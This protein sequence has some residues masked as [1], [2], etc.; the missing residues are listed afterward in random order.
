M[1]K[2]YWYIAGVVLLITGMIFFYINF[3]DAAI[4]S[5]VSG[6]LCLIFGIIFRNYRDK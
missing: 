2:Y 1:F 3:V 5:I 4:A 6:I